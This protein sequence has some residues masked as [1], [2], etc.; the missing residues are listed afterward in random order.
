MSFDLLKFECKNAK[1]YQ[2]TDH[3]FAQVMHI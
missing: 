3:L 1:I 2:H